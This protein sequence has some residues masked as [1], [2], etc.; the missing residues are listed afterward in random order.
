MGEPQAELGRD[1][2]RGLRGG[3][4]GGHGARDGGF[5]GSACGAM[6]QYPRGALRLWL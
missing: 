1:W 5:T 6:W 2:L 4:G 3:H